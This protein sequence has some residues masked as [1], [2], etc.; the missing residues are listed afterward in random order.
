MKLSTDV[1]RK[2]VSGVCEINDSGEGAFF[3]RIKEPLAGYYEDFEGF[4]IR[5]DCPAGVRLRF[6]SD[7]SS[8]KLSLCYADRAREIFHGVLHV[9]GK[10]SAV[11]G[12]DEFQEEWSGEVYSGE[13]SRLFE[14]YMPL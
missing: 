13:G 12:P 3:K 2:I 11:F 10:R 7:T 9:D 14:I 6:V 8:V 5:R 4:R 1:L